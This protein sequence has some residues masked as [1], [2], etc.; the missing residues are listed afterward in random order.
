MNK[1]ISLNGIELALP[2]NDLAAI[3][4]FDYLETVVTD[5]EEELEQDDDNFQMSINFDFSPKDSPKYKIYS[6]DVIKKKAKE[7]VTRI[8]NRNKAR[9]FDQLSGSVRVNLKAGNR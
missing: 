9:K 8:L 2:N 7:K 3:T 1:R 5:L 4:F 6:N